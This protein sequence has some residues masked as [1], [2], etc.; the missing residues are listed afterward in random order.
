VSYASSTEEAVE[1]IFFVESTFASLGFTQSLREV[2]S[3]IQ[4]KEH[5][6]ELHAHTEWFGFPPFPPVFNP[7]NP[8]D[9]VDTD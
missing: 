6:F 7:C 2:V 4:S 1:G 8:H 3:S 5:D 9:F